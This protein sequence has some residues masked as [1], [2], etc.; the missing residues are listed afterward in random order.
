MTENTY[1]PL[2]KGEAQSETSF[3]INFAAFWIATS[4]LA[5]SHIAGISKGVYLFIIFALS[6][7][8]AQ[9]ALETLFYRKTSVYLKWRIQQPFVLRCCYINNWKECEM[10]NLALILCFLP[11]LAYAAD[12]TYGYNP[13]G[14]YVPVEIDGKKVE[15]GYNAH[16]DYVPTAIGNDKI[17][18]G[19]NPHG[20]YVPTSVGKN[21]IDY[22]YNPHGDYVPTSLKKH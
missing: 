16:G 8:T 6:I 13:H 2:K 9:I 17:D 18:Y 15:Y 10:K 5:L 20:D 14:E 19:Y 21:K 22:G 12:I 7:T 1:Y 4:V 3:W 11:V